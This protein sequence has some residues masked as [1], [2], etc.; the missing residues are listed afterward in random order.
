MPKQN[1]EKI[2]SAPKADRRLSLKIGLVVAAIL[3][4]LIVGLL[5]LRN[6]TTKLRINNKSYYVEKVST[7][8]AMRKGLS[9][10]SS[11]DSNAVMQFMFT[12]VSPQC[13]WMKDM[14]FAIDIVW[15]DAANS[16]VHIEKSVQPDSYPK[17]FCSP[18]P[19]KTVLEMKE[20]EASNA[21]IRIGDRIAL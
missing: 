17:N 2:A 21:N 1:A 16:V 11:I 14:N 18:K 12:N 7:D 13:M 6:E 10:R 20:G 9:G 3:L 8:Q 15:L 5:L 19:A 4:C